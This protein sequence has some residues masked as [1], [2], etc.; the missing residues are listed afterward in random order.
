[1][2]KYFL[3]GNIYS[4]IMVTTRSQDFLG[5]S[6][7]LAIDKSIGI[8]HDRT[9]GNRGL[10][11]FERMRERT[12]K[13]YLRLSDAKLRETMYGASES[14]LKEAINNTTNRG[15]LRR[16]IVAGSRHDNFKSAHDAL[17]LSTPKVEMALVAMGRMSRLLREDKEGHYAALE[18]L[19]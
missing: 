18:I 11:P 12:I 3:R 4:D 1:M 14:E 13:T 5:Q 7:G 16:V 17:W 15:L 9:P 10:Y 6:I 2:L 8:R 19:G